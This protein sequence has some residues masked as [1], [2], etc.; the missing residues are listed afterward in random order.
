MKF[1]LMETLLT[2]SYLHIK[3]FISKKISI[4]WST[5]GCLYSASLT[6]FRNDN[7]KM[8]KKNQ[9]LWFLETELCTDRN[10]NSCTIK[11]LNCLNCLKKKKKIH[12]MHVRFWPQLKGEVKKTWTCMCCNHIRVSFDL[13]A[14]AKRFL[15][16]YYSFTSYLII[17]LQEPGLK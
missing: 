16:F 3:R 14:A 12:L 17:F 11:S 8:W 9:D 15:R 1:K 7:D 5:Q 6:G 4:K 2:P 10:R 13:T